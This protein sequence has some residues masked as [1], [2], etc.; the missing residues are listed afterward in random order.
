MCIN[1]ILFTNFFSYFK[2]LLHYQQLHICQQNLGPL[3][4][5]IQYYVCSHYILIGYVSINCKH[6]RLCIRVVLLVTFPCKCLSLVCPMS[7]LPADVPVPAQQQ[8]PSVQGCCAMPA[9]GDK[10]GHRAGRVQC[11]P[12]QPRPAECRLWAAADDPSWCWVDLSCPFW[13]EAALPSLLHPAVHAQVS[14]LHC[15][16]LLHF[17]HCLSAWLLWPETNCN[18][19]FWSNCWSNPNLE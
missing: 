19:L 17:M 2:W 6:G 11:F 4:V 8:D 14:Q 10:G 13:G 9:W 12:W 7:K 1:I 16:D 18:P 3:T 5:Y 15:T